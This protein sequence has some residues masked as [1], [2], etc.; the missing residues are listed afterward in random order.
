[1]EQVYKFCEKEGIKVEEGK[2]NYVFRKGR[3]MLSY[4]LKWLKSR[5]EDFIIEMLYNYFK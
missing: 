5:R 1:M 3:G 2:T 4:P